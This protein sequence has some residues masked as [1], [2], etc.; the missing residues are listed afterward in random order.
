MH[1]LNEKN[2]TSVIFYFLFLNSFSK[3]FIDLS[4]LI[5]SPYKMSNSHETNA[6]KCSSIFLI[7]WI[8]IIVTHLQIFKMN[9]TD[10]GKPYVNTTVT[11]SLEYYYALFTNPILVVRLYQIAYPITFVFGF[12]G[13]LASLI[14][15][16]RPALRKVSTSCLFIML[17]ISD[18]LY[19]LICIFDFI[20]FGMQVNHSLWFWICNTV[21]HRFVYM[22]V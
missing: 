18:T 14:T 10:P 3:I 20:E 13:N 16:S 6:Y 21:Y 11:Y 8:S 17:A 22:V 15:F 12:L 1:W 19:L 2:K 7:L 5:F 4:V 9:D